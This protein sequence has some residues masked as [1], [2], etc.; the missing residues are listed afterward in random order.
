[1]AQESFKNTFRKLFILI[2]KNLLLRKYHYLHSAVEIVF[3]TLLFVILVT[4]NN[5]GS[6]GNQQENSENNR[7]PA[8]IP[9]M[10]PYPLEFCSS[11]KDILGTAENQDGTGNKILLTREIYYTNVNG[12]EDISKASSSTLVTEIIE[13]VVKTI[14]D[15]LVPCC[16]VFLAKENITI[17]G[18]GVLSK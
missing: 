18:E 12:N 6:N 7:I 4:I 14:N 16:T 15:V 9:A 5:S 8:N 11:L 1:M 10:E 3:P 17:H 13:T 2:R